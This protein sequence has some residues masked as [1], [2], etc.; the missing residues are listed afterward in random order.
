VRNPVVIGGD[1]H[2]FFV[3]D[4]RQDPGRDTPVIATEF[5]TTSISSQASEDAHYAAL[6]AANRQLR[7]ADGSRRGYLLLSLHRDRLEAN[8]MGLDDVTRE[9]S[10]IRRQ[11]RFVVESGR[12]GARPA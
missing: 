3:A 8:L 12:P 9:D 11:A 6:R 5:V 4:I 7:H 1:L 2:A 10:G